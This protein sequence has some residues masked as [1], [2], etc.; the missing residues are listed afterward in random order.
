MKKKSA[1]LLAQADHVTGEVLGFAVE[2]IMG[3]GAHNVQLIPTITKKNRPGHIVLIDTM[4]AKEEVIAE[5]LIKELK[6]TGYH[7]VDTTHIFPRVT[8]VT[9][10]LTITTQ[11]KTEEFQCEVKLVGDP[12]Q[13]L[14]MDVEHDF[15]VKV[16]TQVKE[17]MDCFISL[18]EL[19]T[20]IESKLRETDEEVIIEL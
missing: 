5:F 11:G 19:R 2:R 7:R 20:M 12:G 15:L 6:V 9:K 17:K 8:Y 16:Q 1:L 13:P 4:A 10:K 3:L 14:C 18:N